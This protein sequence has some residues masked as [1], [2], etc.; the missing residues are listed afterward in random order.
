MGSLHFLA[1]AYMIMHDTQAKALWSWRLSSALQ[2]LYATPC[3]LSTKVPGFLHHKNFR[4]VCTKNGKL[5]IVLDC[6]CGVGI[7]DFEFLIQARR[8]WTSSVQHR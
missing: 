1:C 4:F 7:E 3:S 8:C 6:A 5:C 2:S